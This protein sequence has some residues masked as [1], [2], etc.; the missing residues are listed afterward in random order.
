[1][2][3]IEKKTDLYREYIRVM[4]MCVEVDTGIAPYECIKYDNKIMQ[5]IL[6][7]DDLYYDKYEF[8]IDIVDGKP[9]FTG[10]DIKSGIPKTFNLNGVELPLPHKKPNLK[11]ACFSFAGS[12]YFFETNEDMEKT[13]EAIT[14]LL[15]G[16]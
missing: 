8:A 1:M 2:N 12:Y 10:D 16:K 15:S 13:L 11:D 6:M 14:N 3:K 9:V 7:F 4:D 5:T